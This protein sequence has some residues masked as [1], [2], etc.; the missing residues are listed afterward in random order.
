MIKYKILKQILSSKI[1]ITDRKALIEYVDICL[2][3]KTK[4][5][6]NAHNHKGLHR[7]HI[8]P[9]SVFPQFAKLHLHKWN[10]AYLTYADHYTAHYV[11][12]KALN[13]NYSVLSAFCYMN[14]MSTVRG[15]L[16]KEELIGA[17]E[18]TRVMK[19]KSYLQSLRPNS[20]SKHIWIY[21]NEDKLVYKTFGNFEATCEKY[22]LPTQSLYM[23]MRNNIKLYSTY[24]SEKT[25]RA[26]GKLA[27]R[28][29]YAKEVTPEG[30]HKVIGHIE[31]P[32]GGQSGS[33]N[34]QAAKVLIYD[35]ND[36]LQAECDGNIES[37]CKDNG[38]PLQALRRSYTK[39][40][41]LYDTPI[42]LGKAKQ[43]G[44]EIYAGWYAV[45]L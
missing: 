17:E 31:L 39:N 11:L 43:H 32:Y 38:W 41:K 35:Q 6:V 14:S 2:N 3:H 33:K 7:H 24:E 12:S 27:Y 45:K 26:N 15:E 42:G 18:Y 30:I 40:S 28:H 16:K 19:Q 25:A 37:V 29:W 10:E 22:G 23:S 36:N 34:P 5:K 4:G 20:N 21:D 9:K 8:L 13:N 44:L 1:E